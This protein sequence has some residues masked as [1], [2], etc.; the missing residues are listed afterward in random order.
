MQSLSGKVAVVTG[1]T[2]GIGLAIAHA[3]IAVGVDVAVTGRSDAHLAEA[4]GALNAGPGRV[5]ALR[6]DVRQ[7][8]DLDRALAAAVDRF[9]GLDILVNNAGVGGFAKVEDMPP[10]Q[11]AEILDTN[12]TGVFNACHL[13]VPHLRRR[14]G[15]F[16]I[17]ISSLAGSNPFVGG[18]AY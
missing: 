13:A 1:G 8:A 15:G 17:N 18:A 11:W 3:L 2:R 7:A 16:I 10:T 6:A 12:L 14:G 9:G 5:E 4:R